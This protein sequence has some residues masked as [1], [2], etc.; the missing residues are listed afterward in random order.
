M[1]YLSIEL[2]WSVKIRDKRA[3]P[4]GVL[5]EKGRNWRFDT[6]RPFIPHPEPFLP[7]A[8]RPIV[9]LVQCSF[10]CAIFWSGHAQETTRVHIIVISLNTLRVIR[11]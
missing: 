3:S 8:G 1:S 10:L 11:S 2:S 6:I 9:F 7:R 4:R 5:G